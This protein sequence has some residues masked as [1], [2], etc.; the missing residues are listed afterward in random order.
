MYENGSRDKYLLEKVENIGIEEIE[1]LENVLL[2][3]IYQ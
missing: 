2:G 1:L 3:K